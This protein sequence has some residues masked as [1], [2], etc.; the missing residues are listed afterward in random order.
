MK[1]AFNYLLCLGFL[2]LLW[3][4]V[5]SLITA[6]FLLPPEVVL[7]NFARACTT[8]DFWSHF[9]ISA[10]RVVAGIFLGWVL[11]FPLGVLMGYGKRVD[12]IFAPL[13]FITYPIPKIVF[14]PLVLLVFGLGDLSKIILI[15]SI[16]FFQ[17]LVATRDGVRAIDEKHYDSLRSLG[18]DSRVILREVAFPAAL[19]HSFTA[20]RIGIG[21]AISVLFFVES[22]A[23]T[24]G[25]GYLIMDAWGRMDYVQLFNGIV[26]MGFLGILL[27]ETLNLLEPRVCPWKHVQAA[28]ESE[29][30][31][32]G[33]LV[34]MRYRTGVYARMIK[35]EHT[36]FVL[37]FALA[38]LLLAM[39]HY[40]VTFRQIFWIIVAM[41]GARSAAM[42]FNR[43][44]DARIDARNPRTADRELPSG[45]LSV[46]ETAVFIAVSSLLFV[47]SAFFISFTCF[48]C[49]FIVLAS[50][51]GYSFTKRFTSLSH[52]VLGIVIGLS[53]LGV[54]VALTDSLSVSIGMLSLALCTYI[55]GFDILYACQDI[56][57]DRKEGLRSMPV[58]FGPRAAM[59][60]SSVFH[61]VAFVALLSLFWFFGLTLVY[62]G[63]VVVIGVLFII[64]HWL[65]KPDDLSRVNIAFYHVNSAIS[66]LI[67]AALA[68]EELLRR[69]A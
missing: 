35:F 41:V 64:E 68:T 15:T 33:A 14:L 12:S 45:Q 38:A 16:L 30:G 3:K 17:V 47:L 62:I 9:L 37:P 63:F 6:P 46:R 58:R 7:W 2:V 65:V 52:V 19:P 49:S 51:F 25:L 57:F 55:A 42:G 36:I 53:P 18:A 34:K 5:A 39:R 22:F 26:G 21:T 56:E 32:G 1:G 31:L 4:M 43:L 11:A 50:L 59:I 67:F 20:L 44:V 48:W 61:V 29:P 13:V 40:P 8:A 23:T 54:W 60:I 27:Y 66:V 24:T 28:R 69:F 10:Y